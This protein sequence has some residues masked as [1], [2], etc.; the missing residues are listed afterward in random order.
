M[1]FVLS[2]RFLNALSQIPNH[3]EDVLL[4]KKTEKTMKT[5]KKPKLCFGNRHSLRVFSVIQSIIFLSQFLVA[6][7]PRS[8]ELQR[9]DL[10]I[11]ALQARVL[12]FYS[13]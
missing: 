7:C 1:L 6:A 3:F 12:S 11:L 13:F 4:E 9:K 10:L 2:S 8:S 5:R